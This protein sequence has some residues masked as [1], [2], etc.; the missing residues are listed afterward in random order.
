MSVAGRSLGTRNTNGTS[1][2]AERERACKALACWHWQQAG[3]LW[4]C[5]HFKLER[6]TNH[7]LWGVTSNDSFFSAETGT[8]RSLLCQATVAA[9]LSSSG[10]PHNALWDRSAWS[11]SESSSQATLQVTVLL[12]AERWGGGGELRPFPRWKAQC[13]HINS[14][15]SE[16]CRTRPCGLVQRLCRYLTA[17]KAAP[18]WIIP[19]SLWAVLG[20]KIQKDFWFLFVISTS[21]G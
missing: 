15:I 17:K 5:F 18:W 3:T 14:Q 12:E 7:W 21:V 4:A 6:K 11:T 13:N 20:W 16:S 10:R 2:S 8:Y 1:L 19:S 9:V